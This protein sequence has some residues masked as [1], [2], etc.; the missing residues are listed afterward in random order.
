MTANQPTDGLEN[1][2]IPFDVHDMSAHRELTEP[3]WLLNSSTRDIAIGRRA[4]GGNG[5]YMLDRCDQKVLGTDG[6]DW[7][8]PVG[9]K[10]GPLPGE[11][12]WKNPLPVVVMLVQTNR[13]LLLVR[14]AARDTH[15]RIALPGGFQEVGET[16]QEA[17]CRE[18]YEETGVAISPARVR[19]FDVD[20]VENGGVNLIYGIHEGIVPVSVE[21]LVPQEGEIL[22]VLTTE[23]AVETAFES[24]SRMI[25]RHFAMAV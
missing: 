6:F 7:C 2:W 24:H 10:A 15:G 19:I 16:W 14:R 12:V 4:A 11:K 21:K 9:R 1:G 3:H 23:A 25:A 13:G 22:E 20:T 5:I 18:V 8:K 17:G